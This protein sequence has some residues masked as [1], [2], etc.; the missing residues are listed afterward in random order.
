MQFLFLLLSIF[1]GGLW[2]VDLFFFIVAA[3]FFVQAYYKQKSG[4]VTGGSSSN[5]T[6]VES[7]ENMKLT[8]IKAFWVGVVT[9]LLW[10][11]SIVWRIL[12]N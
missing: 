3:V 11:G 5:M 4:T 12:D 9:V 1:S 10:I 8:E 2:G 6:I 7:D